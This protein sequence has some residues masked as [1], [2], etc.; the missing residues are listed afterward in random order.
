MNVTAR[1]ARLGLAHLAD[2][3]EEL[4]QELKDRLRRHERKR[5]P[6]MDDMV[7]AAHLRRAYELVRNGSLRRRPDDIE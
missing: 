1:L 2:R 4:E 5:R 6:S 7:Q 3:H